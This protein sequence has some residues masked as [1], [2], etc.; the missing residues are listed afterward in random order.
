M[1]TESYVYATSNCGTDTAE[2]NPI[3]LRR[4]DVFA[5]DDPFCIARPDLFVA[6][7]RDV[8]PDFP[9]RTVALADLSP[10]PP[11]TPRRGLRRR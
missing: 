1:S 3:N 9:R 11:K 6:D 4:G 8:G 5:A 2:G 10:E 7:C